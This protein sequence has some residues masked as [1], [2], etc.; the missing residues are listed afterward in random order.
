MSLTTEQVVALPGLGLEVRAGRAGLGRAVEW[1]H[2]SELPDPT[3]YLRGGEILLITGLGLPAGEQQR[4]DYVR[5][6]D[7]AA[8]AGLGVALEFG[9]GEVPAAVLGESDRLGLPVFVVPDATPFIAI[10]RAVAH[11][12]TAQR[13]RTTEAALAAQRALTAAAARG[14]DREVARR[15]AVLLSAKVALLDAELAERHVVPAGSRSWLAEVRAELARARRADVRFSLAVHREGRHLLVQPLGSAGRPA[16]Y[17]AVSAAGAADELGKLAATHA[18]ALLTLSLAA[19]RDRDR[20]GRR[21][22]GTVLA[23]VDAAEVDPVAA[24]RLL[25]RLGIELPVPLRVLAL[26]AVRPERLRA[27]VRSAAQVWPG[28]VA[29]W[30]VSGDQVLVAVGGGPAES[31]AALGEL[32]AA[33]GTPVAAGW[34][35]AADLDGLPAAAERARAASRRGDAGRGGDRVREARAADLLSS[36]LDA[37]RLRLFSSAAL[38]PLHR[39][40]RD[41]RGELVATLRAWLAAGGHWEA[42]AAALGTHR[43]TVRARLRRVEELTGRTVADPRHRLELWLAVEA[44]TLLDPPGLDDLDT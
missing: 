22:V 32:R 9:L 12:L 25:D 1:V 42:A 29:G 43:H 3:P 33:A 15:L 16:G 24:G 4:R 19:G 40:D 37:D 39:A 17:L 23:A 31:A 26:T 8:C 6:L 27:A 30:W 7:A 18:A 20:A 34:S 21:L 13:A 11:E 36:A 44:E 38:E 10:S 35:S 14:G 41:G 2:S 5:R 28:A